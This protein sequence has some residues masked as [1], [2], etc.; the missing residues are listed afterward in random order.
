MS[1]EQNLLFAV[2][3]FE[4]EL[5]DLQQLTAACRAWAGDKS[6]PLADLLVERGWIS[7]ED[8]AFL[9]RKAD[10]KLA[11][12]QN[13][14]QTTLNVVT[15]G[16]LCDVLRSE[17]NDTEVRQS[18]GKWPSTAPVL[19]ETL[20][21]TGQSQSRYT[22]I[23]QVGAGGLG[24]VWL[25]NDNNLSREVAVKEV[26]PDSLS[27]EAVRRLIKEAQITGQLQHPGI[28]PV[29]EVNHEGRPFYTM[30]LVKG[31]TLSKAIREH[32]AEKQEGKANL[33]NERRLINI[34]VTIC[35]A[36]AYAHSRGVIHRDLK[37][38]NIVL[39]DYGEAVVL[40]WGLARQIGTDDEDATPIIVS[41]EGR[42]DATQAGQKLGTP[43]YMSPEQAAGRVDHMDARTDIYGLGAI[44]FEILTGEAP[45]KTHTPDLPT[46]DSST[47]VDS[48][49][50]QSPIVVML[51]HI[52]TEEARRVRSVDETIP[53]ELD[54]ICGKTLALHR[55]ERYQT[56]KEL[57]AAV[58]EFQVHE[59]SIDLAVRAT[60]DLEKATQTQNY[61]DFSRA[62]FGF[63]QAI[64]MWP[65]NRNA[66]NGQSNTC[67]AFARCAQAK[68]DLD[69]GMSLL[70]RDEPKHCKLYDELLETRNSVLAR[71]RQLQEQTAARARMRRMMAIGTVAA[72]IMMSGL[73]G[74]ACMEREE[75]IK[76]EIIA[77]AN[78]K[79]ASRQEG[80]ANENANK[81]VRQR[82][83]AESNEK[84]AVASA[85]DALRQ[86][87]I[88]DDRF[89]FAN[90]AVSDMLLEVGAESLKNVPQMEGV[91][92]AL[93][94]KALLLY[95]KIGAT[96]DTDHS[97]ARFQT[98]MA[99]F[100]VG[101]IY[102]LLGTGVAPDKSEI[103]Y[104]TAVAQFKKL[105]EEF[106]DD[107][108]YRQQLARSYMWL[109]ELLRTFADQSRTN[110]AERQYDEAI[111]IQTAL[112]LEASDEN[113]IQ[114]QIDLGR[115]HMNRGIIRKNKREWNKSRKDYEAAEQ[116]LTRVSAEPPQ[117]TA[118]LRESRV[119]L[120]KVL[121]NRGVLLRER[122]MAEQN[123]DFLDD[124]T[125]AFRGAIATLTIAP[126]KGRRPGLHASMHD[127]LDLAKY[128]NNLAVALLTGLDQLLDDGEK[129]HHLEMAS[130]EINDAVAFCE[131]LNVGTREVRVELANFYNTR[132]YLASRQQAEGALAE[133]ENAA[134][135][136]ETVWE[137]NHDDAIATEKLA[138]IRCNICEHY[139]KLGKH[140]EALKTI[141]QLAELSCG[142]PRYQRAAE[143]MRIG[144]DESLGQELSDKYQKM[145]ALF[146]SRAQ[147]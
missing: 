30:K 126:G 86:K 112:A 10:R 9:D 120:A 94:E 137:Q 53:E 97:D 59:E 116:L 39:G 19:V 85:V 140:D 46:G 125:A 90:E 145:H 93:L 11:K 104:K 72:L 64:T 67:L 4:D 101:E 106:P 41:V 63:E 60:E 109:G 22:W 42:T 17:V 57:K 78:A 28:V 133:W 51:H 2:L 34:F 123:K 99:N 73:A 139:Q 35:D 117:T 44:L 1:V 62:R 131:A 20:V 143:L 132:A 52:A 43:A 79:E 21:D 124:A 83:L 47:R 92:A 134:E 70:D 74:W 115:S 84:K 15:R 66:F 113:R 55:N 68:G 45:H 114:Y 122:Y 25:A 136:L 13:D 24:Q 12:H 146:D 135:V 69:L 121:L 8:R 33:I 119:L 23:S 77:T 127:G 32:H 71:E 16:D 98:A 144:L 147:Q 76:Q 88:A 7:A 141:E 87:G 58:L 82:G 37:P 129:Q 18:L 75:A 107:V 103:A 50:S 54:A 100:Q 96:S 81:A 49:M 31:E 48:A 110:E 14:P 105:S 130:G 102:R 142:V 56:A 38:E 138:M 27:D 91:R 5:I 6:K 29:Y 108:R 26:K 80:L 111:A 40:D 128:R 36:I 61:D 89:E 3:A 65:D 118:Q 95:E